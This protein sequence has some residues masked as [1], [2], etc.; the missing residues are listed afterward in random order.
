ME[1]IFRLVFVI[2]IFN[3]AF[4]QTAI[5][6]WDNGQKKSEIDSI[7]GYRKYWSENGNLAMEGKV[8]N[9][10]RDSI[11]SY[12]NE[13][14][15]LVRQENY[16]DN[17]ILTQKKIEYYS[18]WNPWVETYTYYEGDYRDTANF[19][20]HKIE[21]M[22]YETGEKLSAIHYINGNAVDVQCWNKKGKK[23]SLKYLKKVNP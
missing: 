21:T 1:K 6:F 7:S 20:F 11:W 17:Y 22:Y 16:K 9:G 23:K 19:K 3:D 12:Y 8:A 4:S 2:L 10:H 18:N 13:E 14:G 5:T 15:K